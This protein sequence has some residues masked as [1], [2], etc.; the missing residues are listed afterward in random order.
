MRD[1]SAALRKYTG[2]QVATWAVALIVIVAV[3]LLVHSLTGGGVNGGSH[4]GTFNLG[5]LHVGGTRLHAK[6]RRNR[7]GG[8][9]FARTTP[10][11]QDI[12]GPEG[13]AKDEPFSGTVIPASPPMV[14]PF[15]ADY[16][17]VDD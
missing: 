6:V 8:A 7:S 4:R 3:L 13:S 15:P 14:Q 1:I 12:A 17:S 2:L 16:A 5:P 9:P 10:A 11:V